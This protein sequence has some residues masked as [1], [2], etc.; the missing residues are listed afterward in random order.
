MIIPLRVVHLGEDEDALDRVAASLAAVDD[1][2]DVYSTSDADDALDRIATASVDCVV[3]GFE[4][5]FLRTLATDHAAV[6][7]VLFSS[8]ETVPVEVLTANVAAVVRTD[9]PDPFTRVAERVVDVI[10]ERRAAADG[11]RGLFATLLAASTDVVAVVDTD[12][13]FGYVS[14]AVERLL[15][16]DPD[17]LVGEDSLA[18]VHPDDRD[19]ASERLKGLID[20]PDGELTDELRLRH[21]DGSWVWVENRGR[22]LLDDPDVGGIVIYS[23]DVTARR[24]REERLRRYEAIVENMQDVAYTVD[25]SLTVTSVN[26]RVLAYAE[27]P[28][29]SIVGESI[30]TL[31]A[32]MLVD[33]ENVERL[34]DALESVVAGETDGE[35][36]ELGIDLPRGTVFAELQVTPLRGTDATGGEAPQGAVVISRDVTERRG[37][38]RELERQ[39]ERLEAFTSV[40]SHDLR[41][42]LAVASGNLELARSEVEHERLDTVARAHGRMSDL[43]DDLLN[44]ARQGTPV[45]DPDPV[46][47]DAVAEASWTL[48]ETGDATVEIDTGLVVRAEEQR[49]RQFFENLFRN[50]VEHGST[51][52]EKTSGGSVGHGAPGSHPAAGD[53][54]D[55]PATPAGDFVRGGS[56]TDD[57][58]ETTPADAGDGDDTSDAEGA[59]VTVRVGR[60]DDGSAEA[61]DANERRDV[62]AR[63]GFYVEDDGPGIPPDVRDAVFEAGY[64]A[65]PDGTGLGLMI[66]REIADAHG[67][68]V[69]VTDGSTGGARFEVRNV[70]LASA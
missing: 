51:G 55:E 19:R 64:S 7:C 29:E 25:E 59:G 30:E 60:L 3:T 36:L 67:W 22:N 43:I 24:R 66:V 21:A 56:T 23:R 12:G 5:S 39:N 16:Y 45:D 46:D 9:E 62:D 32:E 52:S 42:P 53:P 35:R 63:G 58:G 69:T 44:V 27:R 15:G 4:P 41:G 20:D 61:A 10:R 8:V 47:L 13:R 28:R 6:P 34:C 2:V 40:V 54:I 37:D 14:P 50:S 49:L 68:D 1:R 33:P 57:E 11:D 38:E 26:D 65:K 48:V 31:A 18:Y 70:A 17:D